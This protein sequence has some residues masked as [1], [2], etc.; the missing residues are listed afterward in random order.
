M[1]LDV[2]FSLKFKSH[3]SGY[4]ASSAAL[5]S[6]QSYVLEQLDASSIQETHR[7]EHRSYSMGAVIF[8]AAYLEASIN[9]LYLTAIDRNRNIFPLELLN[10]AETMDHVWQDVERMEV[11]TKYQVALTLARAAPFP[12][13]EPP[14]QTAHALLRLRNALAHHKPEWNTELEE[15]QKLEERLAGKFKESAFAHPTQTFFPHRCLGHGCAAWSVS[16]ALGFYTEFAK[17]LAIN[18]ELLHNPKELPTE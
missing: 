16:T 7:M 3:L 8:S 9:E 5:F 14:F 15:H 17:R 11:L 2:S 4:L 18:V 12:K 13:G 6:R 10:L 1:K